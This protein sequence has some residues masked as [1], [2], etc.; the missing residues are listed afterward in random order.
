M[1]AF[2]LMLSMPR[3]C[4]PS[5]VPPP[6]TF[7]PR[8]L[9]PPTTHNRACRDKYRMVDGEFNHG[10]W[11]EDEDAELIEVVRSLHESDEPP[12]QNVLWREVSV[13]IR[14]DFDGIT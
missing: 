9:S 5:H 7:L 14:S 2:L 8:F 6:S 11:T 1:H 12:K 13:C 3:S 10:P 4:S